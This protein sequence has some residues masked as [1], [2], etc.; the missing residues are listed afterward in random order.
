MNMKK[1]I[2]ILLTLLLPFGTVYG[3]EISNW[4]ENEVGSFYAD[5]TEYEISRTSET[6]VK[7]HGQ[8]NDV[9]RASKVVIVFT[10]PDGS[11]TGNHVFTTDIGEFET[12]FPLNHESQMGQYS[13]FVSYDGKI[14][15]QIGFNVKEKPPESPFVPKPVDKEQNETTT[16][17]SDLPPPEEIPEEEIVIPEDESSYELEDGNLVYYLVTNGKMMNMNLD[18]TSA[19]LFSQ[20]NFFGDGAITLGIPRHV[21]DAKENGYDTDFIVKINGNQV[22]YRYVESNQYDRVIMIDSFAGFAQIEVIG[23]Q[24]QEPIPI[25]KQILRVYVSDIPSW[26]TNMDDTITESLEYWEKQYPSLDL[27]QV[28]KSDLQDFFVLWVKEFGVEHV[29]YAFQNKFVEVGLGDSNCRGKWQP[30]SAD[31]VGYILKHEIGH[32]LGLGH[33]PDPNSIMYPVA[34]NR[35]YGLETEELVLT[36]GYARYIPLCTIRDLTSYDLSVTTDDPTYGF[37]VYVVDSEKQFQNFIDGKPIEYLKNNG[38]YK[39][40]TLNFVG[41]CDTEK[42]NGILLTI[43]DKQ[44][45]SLTNIKIQLQEKSPNKVKSQTTMQATKSPICGAG[46][47]EKDGM[48]VPARIGVAQTGAKEGQWVKYTLDLNT[49][50]SNEFVRLLLQSAVSQAFQSGDIKLDDVEWIKSEIVNVSQEQVTVQNSIRLKNEQTETASQMVQD[51]RLL[52]SINWV[53]PTN[54][55]V[56]DVLYSDETFGEAKVT[57]IKT[58]TYGKK[59]FE[60]IEVRT[61]RTTNDEGNVMVYSLIQNYDKKTGVMLETLMEMKMANIILGTISMDFRIKA[62]DSYTPNTETSGCLIATA[63][64]GSELSSQVQMLREIRDNVLFST[65]SGTTFMTGFNEFYYSFSPTIADLERQSPLFK[66][67]VKMIITPMLSTLSILNYADIN[68]EQAILGYGISIILLNV[69]LYFVV[70]IVVIL[71]I[72]TKFIK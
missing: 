20:V 66:E 36:S 52:S 32:I 29:G 56:G 3:Q 34:Q 48:C 60:T 50:S 6:M 39:E 23:T 57:G 49:D 35:E 40:N 65:S 25:E 21:L 55:E 24:L 14:L 72:R 11:K 13:A 64:Y 27:Q 26:T 58:K 47:I 59:T 5:Q 16:E 28:G 71:K 2:L 9:S 61:E 31:H 19:T 63:T 43:N 7:I 42:G 33:D 4:F 22:G 15:G 46:T 41:S 54:Y 69:G 10:L 12:L 30:Y 45:K 17:P 44:T 70:P 51:L 67:L 68:S 38:C 62:I 37:N 1:L 53:I 8:I 18:K